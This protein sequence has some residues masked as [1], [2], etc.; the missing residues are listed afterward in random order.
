M[1]FGILKVLR[2]LAY[3]T[4]VLV[5]LVFA[6]QNMQPVTVYLVAGP[7]L[8]IPLI[9]AVALAFITGYG[10]ALFGLLLGAA[11]GSRRTRFKTE[12]RS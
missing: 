6:T 7:P 5:L 8:E 4:V 11:R 2:I 12:L 1:R 3:L 9:V 10:F